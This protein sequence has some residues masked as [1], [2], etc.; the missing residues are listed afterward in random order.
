[1]ELISVAAVADN[2]VIGRDGELPWPSI[3]ADKQQYR[4]TVADA[5]VILGRRTF[6]SMRDALPGAHQVIMS[7]SGPSYP[8]P[9]AVT[10]DSVAAAIDAC[11]ATGA[12]AAYV[13]GGAQIYALLQPH[14]DGMHLSRVHGSYEGDSRY[15]PFDP[16]AWELTATSDHDR[17]T[18]ER[19]ARR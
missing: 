4:A 18:I 10:V 9:T 14:I 8:E 5:P 6:E 17:F 16:A 19:W 7:R 11:A 12:E 3:P 1:M 15:P 2:G 13:L